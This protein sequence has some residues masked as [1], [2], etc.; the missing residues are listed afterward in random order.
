M[1]KWMM[2]AILTSCGTMALIGCK[3]DLD[4][5]N[6]KKPYTVTDQE[7]M[8]HAEKTLGIS[9]DQQQDWTLTND[10]SVSISADADMDNIV[11]VA[12]LDADPYA[13]E[14]HCLAVATLSNGGQATLTF[15]APKS[16]E[17]LYA[18]CFTKDGDCM[19]RPFVPGVDRQ[20]SFTYRAPRRAQLVRRSGSTT[21]D[22][23]TDKYYMKD[24]PSFL[25]GL[26]KALPKG[27]NN[28]EVMAQHNYTNSVSVRQNPN[29]TYDLPLVFIGGEGSASDNLSYTWYPTQPTAN[30]EEFIIKDSYPSGWGNFEYDRVTKEYE[31]D[32][33]QLY[34]RN[35]DGTLSNEFS[36]GDGLAFRMAKDEDVLLDDADDRV[37]VIQ[38]NHYVVI[39]CEDGFNWDYNDRMYWLP[40]CQDRLEQITRP[41]TPEQL[42]WTYAWEDQDFGDYD[43]ND[44]V[45]EVR[46][47][48]GDPTKIDITLLALGATRDLWLGFENKNAKSYAD[49]QPIWNEELHEVMGVKPGTMVNTGLATAA[50]VT[51]TVSKPAGFKFQTCSFI[52]GCKHEGNMVGVYDNDYYAISIAAKGQDPHGIAIPAKWQWPTERTC[53]KNAYTAFNTWASDR[54]QAQDWYKHPVAGKVVER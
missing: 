50:P 18:A 22:A 12:V 29:N 9:I 3:H 51:I 52:L 37:K 21:I 43:M 46:E 53:I 35:S 2:A 45:I 20:V 5:D 11:R 39:A 31:L 1:R 8:S 49:Y 41:E 32:G 15:Q 17:V 30:A 54:T 27:S 25:A 19:A 26:K 23:Q 44:C 6:T 13:G 16:A 34:C 33:H 28:K 36:V 48:D 24:F 14:N 40:S 42:V 7:R 38:Y 10:N 4:N 47:H